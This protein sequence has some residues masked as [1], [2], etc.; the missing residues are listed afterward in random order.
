M[1]RWLRGLL[2][3]TVA[4]GAL[5]AG[6][7]WYYDL[8][9]RFPAGAGPVSIPV[10]DRPA[11]PDTNRTWVIGLGDSVTAGFGA[12]PGRSYWSR[13]VDQPVEDDATLLG[14]CLRQ[15]YPNLTATNL[16]QS[17]S[18]S[19]QHERYQLPKV[20]RDVSAKAVVVMTTGGNDLIHSYG[21]APPVEGAMYGATWEQARPW[22]A[23]FGQRLERMVTELKHRFPAGVT[24]CLATIYDPSDGTGVLRHTG[25]R[26]W[27]DGVRILAGYNEEIR[28]TAARHPEVRVVEVHQAFLG[29]GFHC[30]HWWEPH[31][32]RAEPFCWLASN[33][34]DPN[35]RGY[36]AI[37]R[38]MWNAVAEQAGDGNQTYRQAEGSPPK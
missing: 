3:F 29:H 32:D 20:P 25:L 30:R 17:G 6:G 16:S 12:S 22:I 31:Y 34:E 18:T 15:L 36:D 9:L 4:S 27:P 19:L 33:I 11:R 10:R 37:R 14:K 38:L 35:D 2:V 5:A 23:A 21:K 8:F 28:K 13:L 1:N 24:L 26:A 7:A